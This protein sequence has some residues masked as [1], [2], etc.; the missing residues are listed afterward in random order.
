MQVPI[1]RP[2]ITL[3]FYTQKMEDLTHFEQADEYFKLT[4]DTHVCTFGSTY[5]FGKS[6]KAVPK[7]TTGA[8]DEMERVGVGN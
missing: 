7:R 5:R 2:G 8:N 4:R 1:L 6:F 3:H